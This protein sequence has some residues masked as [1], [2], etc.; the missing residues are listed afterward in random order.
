MPKQKKVVRRN[1]VEKFRGF[2]RG[3]SPNDRKH[4][5][6]ILSA[7]RG[8][9]VSKS[10]DSAS[11]VKEYGTAR[12]RALLTGNDHNIGGHMHDT[13]LD[14]QELKQLRQ[15]MNKV[16]NTKMYHYASHVEDA[17]DI[18]EEIGIPEFKGWYDLD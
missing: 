1:V 16:M 7:V 2:Y 18:L 9:D 3:L 14:S 5:Y 12:I 13:P 8:P 10:I 15:Y 17:L 6:N 11:E 4:L